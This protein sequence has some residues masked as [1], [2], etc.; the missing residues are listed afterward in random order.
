M[1]H[2]ARFGLPWLG[3]ATLIVLGGSL[4][5]APGRAPLPAFAQAVRP[6]APARAPSPRPATDEEHCRWVS[7]ALREMQSIRPG[8]TRAALLPVFTTEGGLSTRVSRTYV[9]RKCPYL[10]VDVGFK[11]A[12]KP[13]PDR[14]GRIG[15]GESPSDV[16]V[17]L[18][19][20]YLYWS[21]QD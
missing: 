15:P 10:K 16:I 19:R 20:P 6:A 18:S 2:A 13:R 14:D 11:A 12:G 3:L 5:G 1:K 17:S 9:Y 21:I 4:A 8:M 7:A